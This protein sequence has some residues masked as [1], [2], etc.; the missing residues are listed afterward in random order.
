[1]LWREKKNVIKRK[2]LSS[3]YLMKKSKFK[4]VIPSLREKKRYLVFEV[5]SKGKVSFK[6]MY[7]SLNNALLGFLGQ[8]GMAK[9][10]VMIMEDKWDVN[11]QKGIIKLDNKS[12]DSVKSGL[13]FVNK[14][15]GKDAIVKTLGLSGMINKAESKF[16]IKNKGV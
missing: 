10:G 2:L 8:F 6:Q 16:L 3:Q 9:A 13:M 4:P 5:V 1:M 7:D 11:E 14:I 12:V 15:D